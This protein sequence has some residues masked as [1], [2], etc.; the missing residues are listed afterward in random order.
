VDP[1]TTDVALGAVALD[2]AVFATLIAAVLGAGGIGA[3]AAY[4]K[5]GPENEDLAAKTMAF[6]NDELRKELARR[7]ELHRA[8]LH[9]RDERI[10]GL[11]ERV[12]VLE[13]RL[14]S[15]DISDPDHI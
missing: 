2:P 15:R 6:V 10:A 12:A 9:E 14:N 13:R 8:E 5:V 7:D 1:V 4:R 3:F 11:R